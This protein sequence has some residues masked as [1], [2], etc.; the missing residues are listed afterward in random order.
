M[1]SGNLAALGCKFIFDGIGDVE[2]EEGILDRTT[3][4]EDLVEIAVE[5]GVNN[6]VDLSIVSMCGQPTCKTVDACAAMGVR[7]FG[8]SVK[9]S[10]D[11]AH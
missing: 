8:N 10:L 1:H 2:L 3:L 6:F 7:S 11:A 5:I 9:C 4:G